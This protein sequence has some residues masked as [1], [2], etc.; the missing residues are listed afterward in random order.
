MFNV[1]MVDFPSPSL[2]FKPSSMMML[3]DSQFSSRQLA[4]PRTIEDLLRQKYT[5]PAAGSKESSLNLSLTSPMAHLEQVLANS[6]FSKR[7]KEPQSSNTPRFMPRQAQVSLKDLEKMLLNKSPAPITQRVVPVTLKAPPQTSTQSLELIQKLRKEVQNRSSFMEPEEP[8]DILDMSVV[9]R[10]A[11]WLQMRQKKI[12]DQKQMIKDKELDGCT[13]QP[14]VN[15]VR[16]WTPYSIR[17]K[18]PNASYSGQYE[19]KKKYRSNSVGKLS[20]RSTP[21]MMQMEEGYKNHPKNGQQSPIYS[22]VAMKAGLIY[23]NQ[24][25]NDN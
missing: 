18:S 2:S 24:N 6:R 3:N 4:S 23:K 9:D 1:I 14:Q 15:R 16:R 25:L 17:S 5:K 20:A 7:S 12:D 10:N 19:R 13:F 22:L 11:Y 21:R 8:P